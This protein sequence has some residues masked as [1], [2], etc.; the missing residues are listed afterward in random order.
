MRINP[1]SSLAN[2]FSYWNWLRLLVRVC[3]RI[4]NRENVLFLSY[5]NTVGSSSSR[6]VSGHFWTFAAS[7]TYSSLAM[8]HHVFCVIMSDKVLP[9]WAESVAEFCPIITE[10]PTGCWVARGRFTKYWYQPTLTDP[11]SQLLNWSLKITATTTTHTESF[12]ALPF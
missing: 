12:H 1:S 8:S 3:F 7:D 10:V 4:E 9:L 6:L 11:S 5:C 2:Y